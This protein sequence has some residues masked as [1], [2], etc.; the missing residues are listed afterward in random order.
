M[1][2]KT[3]K[4]RS[5][6]SDTAKLLKKVPGIS[7]YGAEGVSALPVIHGLNDER[8]KVQVNGM[9][10]VSACANPMNPPFLMAGAY[11][12]D[13]FGMNPSSPAQAPWGRNVAGMGRS[14]YVGVRIDL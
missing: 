11:L 5:A 1:I 9:T 6:V 2:S 12:G 13:R 3:N 7:L 10:I 14:V 4:Q 8:V